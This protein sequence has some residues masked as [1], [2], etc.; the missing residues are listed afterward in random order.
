MFS[1]FGTNSEC[2]LYS[3]GGRRKDGSVYE[4]NTK[5]QIMGETILE[6]GEKRMELVTL[7]VPSGWVD[8]VKAYVGQRV[9]VPVSI[10]ASG[11]P[12][13]VSIVKG[14]SLPMRLE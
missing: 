8:S 2:F 13:R 9:T 3:W 6:S 5:V 4:A 11:A 10:Y 1:I 7:L 12:L 14:A